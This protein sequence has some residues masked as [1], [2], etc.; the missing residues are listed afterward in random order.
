MYITSAP[1]RAGPDRGLLRDMP[2]A[3]FIPAP[4]TPGARNLLLQEM[5]E[6]LERAR[7]GGFIREG[8][9]MSQRASNFLTIPLCP[10]CHTGPLGVHGNKAMMRIQKLSELDMLAWTIER[11]TKP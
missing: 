5:R 9:G 1:S 3:E 4:A 11:T 10:P 8:Q 7:L 6:T 2:I